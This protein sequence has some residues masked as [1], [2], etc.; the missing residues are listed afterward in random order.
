[1][2]Q[3]ALARALH[4]TSVDCATDDIATEMSYCEPRL[5]DR[6]AAAILAALSADGY[7][8]VRAELVEAA[9]VIVDNW[10]LLGHPPTGSEID[11][12]R[13][14]LQERSDD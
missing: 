7:R 6:H 9:L 8:L 3:D 2:S 10:T 14:A 4:G 13:S 5:H 12:L 11:A 1:V